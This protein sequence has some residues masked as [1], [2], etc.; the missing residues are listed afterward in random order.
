MKQLIRPATLALLATLAGAAL[1]TAPAIAQNIKIVPVERG[2]E[3]HSDI[4]LMPTSEN[5]TLTVNQCAA[6]NPI[7]LT[8]NARTR[9]YAGGQQVTLAE[10]KA[11]LSPGKVTLMTVFAH[12]KDP[13]VLRVVANVRPPARPKAR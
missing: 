8:V 5:G 2:F 12:L 3:T 9:Y 7:R 10:L 6:C 13:V 11:L 4:V 1:G